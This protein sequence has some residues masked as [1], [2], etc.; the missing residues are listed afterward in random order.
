VRTLS[1]KK[2]L[3]TLSKRHM[4]FELH[5]LLKLWK[6]EDCGWKEHQKLKK[7]YRQYEQAEM[8]QKVQN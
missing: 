7:E 3:G 6:D 8:L 4:I 5:K 2:G 1:L